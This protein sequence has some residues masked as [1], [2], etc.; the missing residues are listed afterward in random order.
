MHHRVIHKFYVD[1]KSNTPGSPTNN[2]Q[3]RLWQKIEES[4]T[5]S[6]YDWE[7]TQEE[8]NLIYVLNESAQEG[9]AIRLL[10]EEEIQTKIQEN[11]ST[12]AE[13]YEAIISFIDETDPN[14]KKQKFAL[15][16]RMNK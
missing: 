15:V 12:L 4:K 9:M 1:K 7:S 10:T 5:G 3:R 11:F 16:R 6:D 14:M 2:E 8:E 13:K